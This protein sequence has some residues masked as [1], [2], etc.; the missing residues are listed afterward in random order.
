[1]MHKYYTT[2]STQKQ[3]NYLELLFTS[4]ELLLPC[5]FKNTKNK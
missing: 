1:M 2:L 3:I 4:S 5:L